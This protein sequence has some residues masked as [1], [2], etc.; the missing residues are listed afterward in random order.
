MRLNS[1][2]NKSLGKAEVEL[3]QVDRRDY[4]SVSF[5]V[6][7]KLQ[8][9]CSSKNIVGLSNLPSDI[10]EIARNFPLFY[11]KFS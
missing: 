2:V 1:T 7:G 10:L 6:P 8:P 3:P 11:S 5:T 4:E 9:A